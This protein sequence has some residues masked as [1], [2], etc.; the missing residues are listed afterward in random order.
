MLQIKGG[1]SG[2]PS[3]KTARELTEKPTEI[4]YF[5]AI[6]RET[7]DKCISRHGVCV[8]AN[9]DGMN[10]VDARLLSEMRN[11]VCMPVASVFVFPEVLIT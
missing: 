5:S 10:G 9:A 8:Y 4:S 7:H 3:F 6:L 1:I 11:I 2:L